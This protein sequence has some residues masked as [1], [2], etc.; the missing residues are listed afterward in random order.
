[1]A[2][3]VEG[4][5]RLRRTLDQDGVMQREELNSIIDQVKLSAKHDTVTWTLDPSCCYSV[6]LMYAKQSQGATRHT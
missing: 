3:V 2:R 1:M 4:H 5:I 6:S